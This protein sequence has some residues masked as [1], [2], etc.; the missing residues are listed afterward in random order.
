MRST[1]RATACSVRA[2]DRPRLRHATRPIA[3]GVEHRQRLVGE[4]REPGAQRARAA[5]PDRAP[6]ASIAAAV[7]KVRSASRATESSGRTSSAGGS[8]DQCAERAAV[9]GEGEAACPHGPR[10]GGQ[11]DRLVARCGRE[12]SSAQSAERSAKRLGPARDGLGRGP[13]AGEREPAI[14]LLP[15]EPAIRGEASGDD[16]ADGIAQL[17]LDGRADEPPRLPVPASRRAL[18]AFP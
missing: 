17:D 2:T 14:G 4:R 9:L 13:E 15:R 11:A 16:R 8:D 12:G 10:A 5:R 7:R 6:G 1:A 18:R 3:V